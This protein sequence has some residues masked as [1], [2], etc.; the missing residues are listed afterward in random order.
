MV[1]VTKTVK[2]VTLQKLEGSPCLVFYFGR[3]TDFWFVNLKHGF[4]FDVLD[5]FLEYVDD[6]QSFVGMELTIEQKVPEYYGGT[7]SFV[8]GSP[9]TND[10]HRVSIDVDYLVEQQRNRLEKIKK[11][12]ETMNTV[13]ELF[14]PGFK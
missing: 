7:V 5:A 2:K 8:V 1:K 6:L 12:V 10:S 13:S 4:H 9:E 11:A 3:K 14:S